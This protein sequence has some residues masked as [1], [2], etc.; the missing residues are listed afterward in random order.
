MFIHPINQELAEAGI[1]DGS[2]ELKKLSNT[3][4]AKTLIVVR[5]FSSN[6]FV[7][8]NFGFLEVAQVPRGFKKLREVRRIHFHLSWYLSEAVVPSHVH[9]CEKVND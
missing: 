1:H 2:S 8:L 6:I 3:N 4:Y 9:F 7:S 5:F